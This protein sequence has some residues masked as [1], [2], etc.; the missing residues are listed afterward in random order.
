MIEHTPHDN[1][2]APTASNRSFG[3]VFTAFFAIIGLLPLLHGGE[4]RIWSLVISTLF[5]LVTTFVDQALAP[6]NQVWMKFGALLHSIVS[7]IALGILF[8]LVVTPIGL[9]MRIFGKDPLRLRFDKSVTTYWIT[10]TPP[11]PDPESL[12]NQF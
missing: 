7:P 1:S 5:L 10:R 12:N 2:V 4:V 8:F 6:L 9:L 11:G 3:F